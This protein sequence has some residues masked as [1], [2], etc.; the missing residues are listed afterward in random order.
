[1]PKGLPK[2]IQTAKLIGWLEREGK[3][4]LERAKRARSRVDK[5]YWLTLASGYYRMLWDL[6][7]HPGYSRIEE[8]INEQLQVLFKTLS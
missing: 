8:Q 2:T 5:F 7:Y 4:A 6:T 3:N 1:M